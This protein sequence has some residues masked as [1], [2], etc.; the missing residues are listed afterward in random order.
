MTEKELQRL[1]LPIL[2]VLYVLGFSNL[3]LR[4]SL[5]VMAPH[6]A[7]EMQLAP[8]QLSLVASSF[9]IAYA[10]MQI[11]TGMLFDRFGP[12]RT[13]SAMLLFTAAGTALFAAATTGPL[14]VAGRVLMGLGCAGVFTGA[15]LVLALW[16][17]KDRVVSASGNLNGVA[18]IGNLAATTPLAAL[19]ALIGW[20][21]SY[22]LF[23]GGIVLLLI[24]IAA[25]LRDAPPGAPP[26]KANDETLR[27]IAAGVREAVRQPG[28]RRLLVAG[29]PMSAGAV[30]A[31][32]WGAPYLR[33]VHGLDDIGRGNVLLAFA[34]ASICG[35]IF[36]GHFARWANSLKAAV[37]LGATGVITGL[38]ALAL[39]ASPPLW[40]VVP[41]LCLIALSG[42]YPTVVMA[43]ARGLVPA[44]L[45][46]RGV[47]ACNMG[48]MTAV[49]G[50]QLVFGWVVG[51]FP[52]LAGAPPPHAYCTAFAV[53][54]A[55]A[56]AALAIYA[57]VR[58]VKPKE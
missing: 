48:L 7:A 2:V 43:H 32:V 19:I 26:R 30:I 17:P 46:G 44:H 35:H 9:F 52:A 55:V 28:M 58:D 18:G 4:S 56:L 10:L 31:G 24:A 6:L 38:A 57:G 49:A 51:L 23:A 34:G 8:W 5:G 27:Q 47:A 41:I 40:L 16:L 33:D 39:L 53:H 42:T 25:V 21:T 36:F 14:L 12:R 54:A 45:M 13:L 15:F 1:F 11:P 3:F 20:R 37:M 29:F 22:W 50:M